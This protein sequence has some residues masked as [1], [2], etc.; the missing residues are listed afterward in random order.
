MVGISLCQP[1]N[2]MR[3]DIK[4]DLPS[5]EVKRIMHNKEGILIHA[6]DNRIYKYD[7]YKC[8]PLPI[9][10]SLT[11]NLISSSYSLDNGVLILF[12]EK[13]IYIEEDTLRKQ[14]KLNSKMVGSTSPLCY[15]ENAYYKFDEDSLDF[16]QVKEKKRDS[17]RLIRRS[18]AVDIYMS[19]VH[20][21]S[22]HII[23]HSCHDTFHFDARKVQLGILSPQEDI[24]Y[25]DEYRSLWMYNCGTSKPFLTE[26]DEAKVEFYLP[27]GDADR[28]FF[29]FKGKEETTIEVYDFNST[30]SPCSIGDLTH[31]ALVYSQ[32]Q[33]QFEI[34]SHEGV[35]LVNPKIHFF[36]DSMNG[37]ISSVHIL[38]EDDNGGYYIGGYGTGLSYYKDQKFITVSEVNSTQARKILPGAYKD[39]SG[40]IRLFCEER[41]MPIIEIQP[42]GDLRF[43]SIYIDE[44]KATTTGYYIDTLSRNRL[45]LGLHKNGLGIVDS[46]IGDRYYIH[47]IDDEQGMTLPNVLTFVEDPVG[48]IW[49]GQP[50]SGIAVYDPALDTVYTYTRTTEMPASLGAF[51]MAID[52]IGTLWMGTNRGVFILRNAASFDITHSDFFDQLEQVSMPDRSNAMIPSIKLWKN[53]VVVGSTAGIGFINLDDFYSEAWDRQV[54]MLLYGVDINGQGTEQNAISIDSHGD[55]WVVVQGGVLKIDVEHLSWDTTAVNI[56]MHEILSGGELLPYHNEAYSIPTDNRNLH[57]S[58]GPRFN[59]SLLANIFFDYTLTNNS[60]DTIFTV[61]NSKKGLLTIPYLDIGN[62]TLQISARRHGVVEDEEL[63]NIHVPPTLWE[64]PLFWV[65][66]IASILGLLFYIYYRRNKIRRKILEKDLAL[67]RLTQEKEQL[68]VQAIISSFNPHFINNSLHWVQSRYRKDENL[69]NLVS[70]LSRN[71]KYIFEK[72]RKGLA[73]HTIEEELQLV[74]SYVT[75]QN[76]RFDNTMR[77]TPPDARTL[78]KYALFPILIMQLQ[79]HVENAIEHGIRNRLGSGLVSI[80]F[81]DKGDMLEILISDDGAGREFA[82]KIG[83]GG[84]QQGTKML[85]N[86]QE[87]YNAHNQSTITTQYIDLK[88]TDGRPCGT[89]VIISLP[90]N[91]SYV[92]ES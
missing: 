23:N 37:M 11:R 53:Y 31:E 89:T 61:F 69:L 72:T 45:A 86:L 18:G 63:I 40:I 51:T 80:E 26:N 76:I 39:K 21:Y 13:Y 32:Y 75:V 50:S 56:K 85:K 90:K 25:M 42:N 65:I 5:P 35:Y 29:F 81:V 91:Y 2:Q 7:G 78:N 67:S 48:R 14:G 4:M 73:Y 79:I 38:I 88:D 92:I 33:D 77:F 34:G 58:F 46:I 1:L 12:P 3:I 68:N 16:V 30:S 54:R 57:V 15:I 60:Q 74:D 17:Y 59:P 64:Q 82:K 43:I 55:M 49:M 6:S 84:T 8:E 9:E 10:E 28:D 41:T 71:I 47:T 87:I 24:V 66:L 44:K 22:R 62:Y 19:D 36:D 27:A 83:S 20:N 52:D 70:G